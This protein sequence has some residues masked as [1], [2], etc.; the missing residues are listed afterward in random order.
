[1][2]LHGTGALCSSAA[3]CLEHASGSASVISLPTHACLSAQ[4]CFNN[5]LICQ[6]PCAMPQK[7]MP[8]HVCGLLPFTY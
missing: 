6:S 8:D 4:S 7:Q 3:Q 2:Y 5:A 1:M